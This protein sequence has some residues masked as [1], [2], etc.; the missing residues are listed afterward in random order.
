LPQC[1]AVNSPVILLD[2]S[3]TGTFSL[4]L[5]GLPETQVYFQAVGLTFG[6]PALGTASSR[7][8]IE[9]N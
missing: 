1:G 9:L 7:V 3:G 6:N 5:P 2:A 8:R 4:P